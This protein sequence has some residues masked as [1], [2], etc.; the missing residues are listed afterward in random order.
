M[1]RDYPTDVQFTQE[2]KTLEFAD[3]LKLYVRA[4]S[5]EEKVIEATVD[6]K[7]GLTIDGNEPVTNA[8]VFRDFRDAETG[9]PVEDVP[10]E[11]EKEIVAVIP[12]PVVDTT[13]EVNLT[14]YTA[15]AEYP[16]PDNWIP[17]EGIDVSPVA[18]GELMVELE[19]LQS[20]Q[21]NG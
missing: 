1:T 20:F 11:V 4:G 9:E 8:V 5:I 13:E 21:I 12:S 16:D 18:S 17:D 6:L 10:P 14:L 3:G 15:P 7:D 2:G 19:A